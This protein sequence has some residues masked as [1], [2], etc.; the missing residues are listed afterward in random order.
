MSLW[1]KCH[2]LMLEA[3]KDPVDPANKKAL[4]KVLGKGG[5]PEELDDEFLSWQ[6]FLLGMGRMSLSAFPSH[7]S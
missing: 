5:V 1:M 7:R 4:K 6:G 2:A 3:F